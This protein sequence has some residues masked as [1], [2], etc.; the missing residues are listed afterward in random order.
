MDRPSGHRSRSE[1]SSHAFPS[2]HESAEQAN[3]ATIEASTIDQWLPSYRI[4]DGDTVTEQG[5]LL[6]CDRLYLPEEFSGFGT[7][8]VLTIDADAGPV[9][10]DAIGV[11]TDGNTV[12][13]SPQRL[14]IATQR[15]PE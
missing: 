5:R 10:L 6:A 7:V 4:L 1:A 3:R 13:A 14:T 12:Y 15:W 11:L 8:A 9:P 2:N